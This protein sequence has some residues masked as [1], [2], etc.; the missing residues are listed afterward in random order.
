VTETCP[1]EQ[2]YLVQV[3]KRTLIGGCAVLE[4][5]IM[6]LIRLVRSVR[7]IK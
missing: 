5:Q 3:G 7:D 4:I 6:A 1:V 2:I